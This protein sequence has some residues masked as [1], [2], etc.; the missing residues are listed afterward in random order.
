MNQAHLP[1]IASQA[2]AW[3]DRRDRDPDHDYSAQEGEHI[4]GNR[5]PRGEIR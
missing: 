1:I 3:T 4:S 5:N 2:V